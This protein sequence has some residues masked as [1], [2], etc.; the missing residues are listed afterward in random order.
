MQRT[1]GAALIGC[2]RI[3]PNHITAMVNNRADVRMVAACDLIPAKAEAARQCYQ[4]QYG[5]AQAPAVKICT[6]YHELLNDPQV[7]MV[8]IATDSGYHHEIALAALAAGKHVLVEKPIAL[9]TRAAR[10]MID[11][12]A[13]RG[14]TLGVC[15]QNRYN[16]A[17]QHLRKALDAGD[18]GRLLYGTVNVRWSRNESYYKAEDWRGTYKLDG[19][20]LMNQSIHG[21]DLLLWTF[22]EPERVYAETDTFL[23]PI[24]A[25]DT[26]VAVVR[27]K[28]GTV[29][30]IEG[31]TCIYPKDFEETLNVFGETGTCC[32]GGMAVNKINHFITANTG[33]VDAALASQEITSVYG[34][35]HSSV[36]RDFIDAVRTGRKPYID[37]EAGLRAVQ[38]ILAIYKSAA[39]HQPVT[40]PL[41]DYSTLEAQAD[42]QRHR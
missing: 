3:A 12:A 36:Y 21:I 8:V 30:I 34:H 18:F 40:F 37:G 4:E 5:Q 35:G 31:T 16:P 11:L 24:E 2:G 27:F 38:M 14:L 42:Y 22:G 6:D 23:R 28:N 39:T 25:E 19:G 1:L 26:A 13:Q 17:V 7:D 32:L 41:G 20:C 9:D 10:Q 15:H 29:G 33:A